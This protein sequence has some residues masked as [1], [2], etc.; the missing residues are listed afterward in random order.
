MSGQTD[1]GK[2]TKDKG[3]KFEGLTCIA[4]GEGQSILH[5]Y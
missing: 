4:K 1:Q 2:D 3:I 5:L